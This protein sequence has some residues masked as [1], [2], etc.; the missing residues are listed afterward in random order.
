MFSGVFP[1][2]F[3]S[4]QHS[5]DNCPAHLHCPT[6]SLLT[7]VFCVTLCVAAYLG[8][9]LVQLPHDK[10]VHFVTFF[11]LTAEFYFIWNTYR[12]WRLTF[13]TMTL[14]ASV[15]LEY[16]QNIINPNR[17]FD[18]VDI[19]YNVHGSAL[20][21]VLCCVLQSWTGRRRHTVEYEVRGGSP[22]T[23]L[24]SEDEDYVNIRM[25]E[26]EQ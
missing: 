12:P 16:A 13:L 20:A 14:G 4:Y 8:F 10:V 2:F 22:M 3:I 17:T 11:L 18:Y 23:L 5:S 21:L 25:D 19:V 6:N 1:V 26:L 7:P 9:S 15:M 24:I